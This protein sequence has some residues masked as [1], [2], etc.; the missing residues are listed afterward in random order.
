L[1]IQTALLLGSVLTLG[2]WLVAGYHFSGR[3]A[4]TER[5]AAERNARYMHSQDLL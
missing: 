2:I 1:T 5:Q 3:I 4:A